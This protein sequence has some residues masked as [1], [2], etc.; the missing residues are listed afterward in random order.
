MKAAARKAT[1]ARTKSTPAALLIAAA[2]KKAGANS[3]AD[4]KGLGPWE[5]SDDLSPTGSRHVSIESASLR[6]ATDQALA[7]QAEVSRSRRASSES[8]VDKASAKAESMRAE[9]RAEVLT[10]TLAV[11]LALALGLTLARILMRARTR[12]RTRTR[13]RWRARSLHL[14]TSPYI[15]LHLPTSPLYL[16]IPRP[17]RWRARSK[18]SRRRC[19][20]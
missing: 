19:A 7:S 2:S 15:S 13:A 5:R 9:L 10:R 1:L 14:P 12:A 18:G 8:L 17:T 20:S 16:P 6:G 4:G 11:A 3:K